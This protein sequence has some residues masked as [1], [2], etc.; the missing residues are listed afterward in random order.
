M[1]NSDKPAPYARLI[2]QWEEAG[3]ALANTLST[4]LEL[5]L[6]VEKL[7][8]STQTIPRE[9]LVSRIDRILEPGAQHNAL[10]AQLA[11]S[12]S[13]LSRTRNRL[14]SPVYSLPEVALSKIFS[15]V[16][17]DCDPVDYDGVEWQV[18]TFYRRLY[19][20]L[21]VCTIWKD[22]GI[23]M[24][25]FWSIVPVIRES[26]L[27]VSRQTVSLGLSRSN[28]APLDLVIVVPGFTPRDIIQDVA[29]HTSRIRS[30]HIAL[31]TVYK[32]QDIT[33]RLTEFEELG[34]LSELSLCVTDLS[35]IERTGNDVYSLFYTENSR[36]LLKL[37]RSLTRLSLYGA[38]FHWHEVKFSTRLVELRLQQVVFEGTSLVHDFVQAISSAQELQYLTLVSLASFLGPEETHT[39]PTISLPK[40]QSLV[41]EDL[42]HDPLSIILNS[43]EPGSHKL[44]MYLTDKCL[45]N[46]M[47]TAANHLLLPVNDNELYSL[48]R[49]TQID[50]LIL[51]EDDS[52]KLVRPSR[53]FYLLSVT[54]AIKALHLEGCVFD[55][56]FCSLLNVRPGF[57]A[58]GP[59][60]DRFPVIQEWHLTK[61]RIV[62]P[63][64]FQE[65]V[66]SHQVQTMVL[67]GAHDSSS[68]NT[69]E[70]RPLQSR[71]DMVEWLARNIP[72]FRFEPSR[73]RPTRFDSRAWQ[74]LHLEPW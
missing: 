30:I 51:G 40:L 9:D 44:T 1:H 13:V 45:L 47:S 12:R 65:L 33:H 2:R 20:L 14:T 3:A 16:V 67:E 6:S 64:A 22:F 55:T 49:K 52:G 46:A 5:C 10:V 72:D 15:H 23:S 18:Q 69:K 50:R 66:L 48:L 63:D 7:S 42:Y 25:P 56:G 21:G 11:Q 59:T 58:S 17:Y 71:D 36:R 8:L 19:T 60:V 31:D 37:T 54:K 43:I 29:K 26:E 41:L 61:A 62:N 39:R 74:R 57:D 4:Y 32:V 73:N 38:H 28:T 24:S 35:Y 27:L 68:N 34:V 70:W 53:I